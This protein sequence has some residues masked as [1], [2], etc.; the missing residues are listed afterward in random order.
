VAPLVTLSFDWWTARLFASIVIVEYYINTSKILDFI[1]C[2]ILFISYS[3]TEHFRSQ[4]DRYI[5]YLNGKLSV[6]LSQILSHVQSSPVP[7]T[8]LAKLVLEGDCLGTLCEAD[9]QIIALSI[10]L[11]SFLQEWWHPSAYKTTKFLSRIRSLL[12][13]NMTLNNLLPYQESSTKKERRWLCT[14]PMIYK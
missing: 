9:M 13:N 11:A 1:S 3:W 2:N 10:R 6:K 12:R 14:L 7:T 4:T 8:T 5:N